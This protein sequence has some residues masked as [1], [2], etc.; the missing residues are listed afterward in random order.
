MLSAIVRAEWL[1]PGCTSP[2]LGKK[3]TSPHRLLIP[4][5]YNTQTTS[6][7]K[8]LLLPHIHVPIYIYTLNLS[9]FK[10]QIVTLSKCSKNNYRQALTAIAVSFHTHTLNRSCVNVH[11][12]NHCLDL[13]INIPKGLKRDP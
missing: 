8:C 1:H 11:Q 6:N 5:P 12:W 13:T 10:I 4:R 2:P 3:S 9:F 7:F